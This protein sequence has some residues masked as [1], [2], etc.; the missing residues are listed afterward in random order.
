[1][2]RIFSPKKIP[3]TLEKQIFDLFSEKHIDTNTIQFGYLENNA[4]FIDYFTEHITFRIELSTMVPEKLDQIICFL[5]KKSL[6]K[7]LYIGK[8][9]H[10]EA[11]LDYITIL[12][13]KKEDMTEILC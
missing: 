2:F 1:M 4:I 9:R 8:F 12:F 13:E 3:L 7:Y 6:K 5:Y 11:C 10:M